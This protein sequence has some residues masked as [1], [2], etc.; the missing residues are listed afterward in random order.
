MK[1]LSAILIVIVLAALL[2][3]TTF[4]QD[5]AST[6]YRVV[7]APA[8]GAPIWNKDNPGEQLGTF[9]NGATVDVTSVREADTDGYIFA[10]T[11]NPPNG[12][13]NMAFLEPVELADPFSGLPECTLAAG[14]AEKFDNGTTPQDGQ[15]WVFDPNVTGCLILFEGRLEAT[16]AHHIYV[17]RGPEREELYFVADGM[18]RYMEGSIW[19]YGRDTNLDDPLAGQEIAAEFQDAKRINMQQNGYDWPIWVHDSAGNVLEFPVGTLL[20][21]DLPDNCQFTSPLR[22]S[23]HGIYDAETQAFNAS[24]GAE[25]CKTVAWLDGNVTQWENARDNVTFT[26][27]EAWLMPGLWDQAQIDAW[28]AAH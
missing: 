4:A 16:K 3:G 5:G 6:Q 10:E 12:M 11:A 17:L 22:V 26:A 25:G 27:I 1:K 20:N 18:W 2:V 13:I 8:D 9:P 15:T 14:Q 21:V 19:F 7:N 23:V 24:I 28:I